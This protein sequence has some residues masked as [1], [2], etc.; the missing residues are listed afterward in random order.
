MLKNHPAFLTTVG[1]T[2]LS[3]IEISATRADRNVCATQHA[4]IVGGTVSTDALNGGMPWATRVNIPPALYLHRFQRHDANADG[5]HL[6]DDIRRGRVRFGGLE[7]R[8]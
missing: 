6:R 5:G 4:L 2:F 8:P 1:Q 7:D 3:A